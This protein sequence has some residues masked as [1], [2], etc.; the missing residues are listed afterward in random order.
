MFREP[1]KLNKSINLTQYL[2]L[3][4]FIFTGLL[5]FLNNQ[6]MRLPTSSNK[7]DLINQTNDYIYNVVYVL[8]SLAVF[9]KFKT[10]KV[11]INQ[12]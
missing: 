3:A 1:L 4:G 11:Q 12:T 6:T 7:T 8:C 5:P 10:F 2:K 9:K